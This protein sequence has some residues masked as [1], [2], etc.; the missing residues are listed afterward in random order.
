MFR[1]YINKTQTIV[2]LFLSM[3][4]LLRNTFFLR[5][6][7]IEDYASL[8]EM[9]IVQI[10]I[11]VAIFLVITTSKFFILWYDL[12]GSSGKWWLFLYF[13]GIFSYFWSNNPNFSG[14]RA[15]EFLILSVAL[16]LIILNSVNQETAQKYVFSAIWFVLLCQGFAYGFVYSNSV[17]ATAVM[18]ACYSWGE[19][20]F[21]DNKSKK[22]FLI[23]GIL[24]TYF[25]VSSLSLASWWALLIGLS[26]LTV[27]SN[28]KKFLLILIPA[29]IIIYVN[30]DQVTIDKLLYREKYGQSFKEALH[31]R[32]LIWID[33][34][35]AFKEKPLL[36]YGYAMASR[37]LG[38]IRTTNA[39][40]FIFAVSVNLGITGFVILIFYLIKLCLELI[41]N[42]RL[43]S[44]ASIS[45]FSALIAGLVNGL[46]ISFIGE[47]WV[48]TSFVFV[49]LFA[50]HLY[51][52]ISLSYDHLIDDNFLQSDFNN[53]D[54]K[55][56]FINE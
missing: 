45:L 54:N 3:A 50:L 14:Y 51:N 53:P 5:R 18:I 46:S 40:N 27:F 9:A 41:R 36:G 33:Y 15:F 38:V 29:I 1:E 2:L 35:N 56:E 34:W 6:R 21:S 52:N 13:F 32:D 49:S 37:E 7:E 12:K 4:W 39:H 25:V 11:V 30:L 31:G 42:I 47:S 48:V 26:L 17:G 10:I 28:N 24:A 16:M 22:V 23:S 43:E 44:L 55:Q 20:F 19:V 8:D